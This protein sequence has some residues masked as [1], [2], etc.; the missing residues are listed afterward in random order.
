[1]YWF[2]EVWGENRISFHI[3]CWLPMFLGF[4]KAICA[5]SDSVVSWSRSITFLLRTVCTNHILAFRTCELSPNHVEIFL[6]CMAT[7]WNFFVC[8]LNLFVILKAYSACLTSKSSLSLCLSRSEGWLT[9]HWKSVCKLVIVLLL[10]ASN[11]FIDFLD[12]INK[13]KPS[14][15]KVALSCYIFSEWILKLDRC[16]TLATAKTLGMASIIFFFFFKTFL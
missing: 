12:V 3:H 15:E 9:S 6:A 2:W 13:L 16:F 1:M 7:G 14:A 8:S 5:Y 4:G 11:L 10:H